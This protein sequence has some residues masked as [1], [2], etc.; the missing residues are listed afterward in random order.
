MAMRRLIS[1]LALGLVVCG[2]CRKPAVPED[3]EPVDV[4]PEE[5]AEPVDPPKPKE[6]EGPNHRMKPMK[7]KVFPVLLS[8]VRIPLHLQGR[9]RGHPEEGLRIC[10][11]RGCTGHPQE[12]AVLGISQAD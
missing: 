12:P 6:P 3:P 1:V 10:L 8:L 5:P 11:Q 9:R 7:A 4:V 2:G